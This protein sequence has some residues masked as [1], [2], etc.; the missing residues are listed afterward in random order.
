MKRMLLL[1]SYPGIAD[2]EGL[3]PTALRLTAEC[4]AIE[5]H[6]QNC[7]SRDRTCNL[8]SQSQV[9]YQLS[10]IAIVPSVGFEPTTFGLRDR[11][12]SN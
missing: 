1:L 7:D 11:C 6:I 3:E 9:L 10:H 12:S 8:L 4:S 5:L 2:M